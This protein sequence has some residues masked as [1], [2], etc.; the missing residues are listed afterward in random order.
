ML[1]LVS[2]FQNVA[3]EAEVDDVSEDDG[4]ADMDADQADELAAL[5]VRD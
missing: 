3:G 1:Y 5:E 2:D 4:P